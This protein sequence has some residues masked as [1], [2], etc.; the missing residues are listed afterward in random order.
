MEFVLLQ[1]YILV[2]VFPRSIMFYPLKENRIEKKKKSEKKNYNKQKSF[3]KKM[4][5]LHSQVWSWLP[6]LSNNTNSNKDR[7]VHWDLLHRSHSRWSQKSSWLEAIIRIWGFFPLY[8]FYYST[9]NHP[10]FSKCWDRY[11]Y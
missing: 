3:H 8:N 4:Y 1:G 2:I 10:L 9:L 7:M 11:W 6:Y 5:E